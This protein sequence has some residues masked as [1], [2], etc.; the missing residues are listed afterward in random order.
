MVALEQALVKMSYL[1][2]DFPEILE[3]DINPL[4][5]RTDGVCAL[6][7]RIVIEPKDVR[8]IALPGAHLM[9]SMYPS[10]YRWEV[11]LDGE[12]VVIRAIK[13]EDEPLWSDM[14]ESLS[15][16]TAEYRFFGPISEVTKSML[17]RYCHIDYDR[18][19][20]LAAIREPKGKKKKMMLGVARLT[21]ETA[22]VEEGEFA[23]VVRDAYQRKGIGS[24]L[25]DALIQAARDR[26]VREIRGH[27]LA[28][29]PGM[30][31]FAEDLGLRRAPRRR[32]GG[33]PAGAPALAARAATRPRAALST[34]GAC[35]GVV[36]VAD[37]HRQSVRPEAPWGLWTYVWEHLPPED[38][39][40][41][42]SRRPPG[43]GAGRRSDA[44][45]GRQR[46]AGSR[47]V[48]SV[49]VPSPSGPGSMPAGRAG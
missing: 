7:A 10:K 5:V 9:I 37:W 44:P 15:P 35:P 8:K 22:N 6:D 24:K 26:H 31:R 36:C 28:A 11:P 42:A 2:V 1:L 30:T 18:E 14:I 48:V 29:N 49:S 41:P 32:A 16:A 21:I 39:L 47:S 17:V 19:I 38:Y 45:A 40:A 46:S 3:M 34:G 33:A 27:V 20:A 12:D 43:A 25:M 23:I 13:P 4:Q